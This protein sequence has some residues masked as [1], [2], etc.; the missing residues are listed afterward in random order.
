M[1]TKILLNVLVLFVPLPLFWTLFDQQGS[2]W[3][4]QAREMNGNIGF[5]IIKPDQMQVF[6][7]LLVL[8]SIPLFEYA[9]YPLMKFVKIRRPLQK[10]AIG[11]ILAGISF[12]LSM[13]VQMQI[14]G[15]EVKTVSIFWQIP[16]YV[17]MTFGEVKRILFCQLII[18]HLKCYSGDVFCNRLGIL[19]HASSRE[20]EI[21]C[22][23]LLVGKLKSITN[24]K[25]DI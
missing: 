24:L 9:F 20:H 18:N 6:N 16:Q 19:V 2:R 10:M 5:I 8:I 15:S 12:I 25:Q 22:S 11:G 21:G 7:P 17:V 23:N 13:L 1:E 3:T 4:F 14:D